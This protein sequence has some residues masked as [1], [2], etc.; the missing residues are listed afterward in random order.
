MAGVRSC[1]LNV[2]AVLNANVAGQLEELR[3]DLE[4]RPLGSAPVDLELN[5][6]PGAIELNHSAAIYEAVD[7]TDGEY[8]PS[9]KLSYDRTYL[10]RLE[11][12]HE[13]DVTGAERPQA[14][15]AMDRDLAP[16]DGLA[17][18]SPLEV[19]AEGVSP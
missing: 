13:Q 1:R 8:V 19:R 2:P 11:Q 16:T 6:R 15:R 3:T 4:P 7:L 14:R 9:S 12:A 17:L 5:A 10:F 18:E